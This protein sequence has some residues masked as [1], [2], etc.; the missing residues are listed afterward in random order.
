MAK[1]CIFCTLYRENLD[2]LCETGFFFST[3]DKHPVVPNH[4]LIIPKRHVI[5]LFELNKTEWNDL[6]KAIANT[7]KVIENAE[8]KPDGYNLG[9]NEGR[10]AGRTI[11]HLHIHLIPRYSGDVSFPAGGVRNVIKNTK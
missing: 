9:L 8:R 4:S 7:V 1:S 11:D 5:S 6:Q 2:I 3:P 10:A